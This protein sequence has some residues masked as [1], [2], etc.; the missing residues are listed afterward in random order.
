MNVAVFF[1]TEHTETTE[2]RT[3]VKIGRTSQTGR[4]GQTKEESLD[5][6]FEVHDSQEVAAPLFAAKWWLVET[7]SPHLVLNLAGSTGNAGS[8][9]GRRAVNVG[10]IGAS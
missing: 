3:N 7:T 6:L 9:G 2:L 1:T 8:T 10:S 5:L 4:T